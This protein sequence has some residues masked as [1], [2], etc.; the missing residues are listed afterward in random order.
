M[1]FGKRD[2]GTAWPRDDARLRGRKNVCL[3][4]R[5]VC[6]NQS[7]YLLRRGPAQ[8]GGA[9]PDVLIPHQN[10][11]CVMLIQILNAAILP[12]LF[13]GAFVQKP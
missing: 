12:R 1:L 10:S 7:S 8:T 4:G 5:N 9:F 6:K 2:W 13:I 3:E 11:D